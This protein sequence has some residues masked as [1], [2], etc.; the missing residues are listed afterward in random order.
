MF[1]TINFYK[2]SSNTKYYILFTH[3]FTRGLNQVL[4][5]TVTKLIKQQQG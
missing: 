2:K 5:A 1:D 3:H 4:Y